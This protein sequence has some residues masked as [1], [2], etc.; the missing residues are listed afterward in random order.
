MEESGAPAICAALRAIARWDAIERL[1]VVTCPTEVIT[2][3]AEP[4]IDRQR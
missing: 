3:D 4:D 2:G 1:N